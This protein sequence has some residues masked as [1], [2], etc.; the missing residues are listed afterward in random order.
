MNPAGTY[1]PSTTMASPLIQKYAPTCLQDMVLS[2]HHKLGPAI[3]FITA[4]HASAWLLYGNTGIG[5]TSLAHIMAT[6]AA[7]H[8]KAVIRVDGGDLNPDAVRELSLSFRATP[9]FGA[10]HA[11]VVDQ[12]ESIPEEGQIRLLS[13][14]D[15]LGPT[16]WIFTA[17]AVIKNLNPRLLSRLKIQLMTAQGIAPV[18]TK[19]LM[20][21]AEREGIPLS[22][23]QA[24]R[25]VKLS[26]N[27][28]RAALQALDLRSQQP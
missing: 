22:E 2:E 12:A 1:L 6:A 9:E 13:V 21:I 28:L 23:A 3:K 20:S 18:A 15:K 8:P 16:A 17:D 11:I 14:L 19:W 25:S 4:P 5:K 24:S 27:D 26:R 7:G 10:F